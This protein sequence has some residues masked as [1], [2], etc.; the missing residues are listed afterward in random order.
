VADRKGRALPA[1]LTSATYDLQD[2]N[3][4]K[5]GNL[6]ASEL[7]LDTTSGHQVQPQIGLCC[8]YDGIEFDPLDASVEIDGFQ[9]VYIGGINSCNDQDND[10]SDLFSDWASDDTNIATMTYKQ[11][12]GVAPGVTSGSAEACL[13]Y[14]D[15]SCYMV[16]PSEPILSYTPVQHNYPGNP[17]PKACWISQYFDHIGKN[18][19]P[20]HAED[21]VNANGNGGVAPALG[22][23][24]YAM[25]AGTVTKIINTAGPAPL[26]YPACQGK[27]YLANSIHVLGTD[28]Y[29]TRYVHTL[30]LASIQ[31]GT[32]VTA[33]QEL[34]T[35]DNSGCQSGPHLHTG[36][37]DSNG[38]AVN[39]TVP[40]TNPLPTNEFW[41]GLVDDDDVP[42]DN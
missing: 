37:Y 23:A 9:D 34:G 13:P 29:T 8:P 26:G 30:A 20:H 17:L 18:G 32:K 11:V 19:T 27:G 10:I 5:G 39:F 24:V 3:R 6:I 7:A 22:T 36:R 21:V 31:V 42:A 12:Q 4:G 16:Y 25:E 33:G 28:G 41:D 2:L 40:C 35:L 38:A 14:A 15:C 1:D